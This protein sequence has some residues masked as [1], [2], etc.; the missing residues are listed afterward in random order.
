MS[1]P[2]PPRQ[3]AGA[4]PAAASWGLRSMF[5]VRSGPGRWPGGLRAAG[6]MGAPVLVG[7]LAGDLTAGLTATLG[8]FTALYGSGRPYRNRAALLAVIGVS[9]AAAV[10]LGIWAASIT[11]VGVLTVA[12]IATVA[13]LLCNS[14]EVGP[15]GAYQFA[16]VCAVG[17]G[18]HAS[19]QNPFRVAL[20]VLAGAGFAWAAHMT[21]ALFGA[22]QPENTAVR[23]AG[24]AVAAYID[25]VGNGGCDAARHQAAS[26]MYQA[27]ATLVSRQPRHRAPSPTVRQLQERSRQIHMLFADAMTGPWRPTATSTCSPGVPTTRQFR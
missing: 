26:A 13:T 22:R 20:L 23:S 10:G 3:A 2:L 8:G 17:T 9:L 18:L 11:I 4:A 25:S 6:C 14:L 5:V 15:P 12:A 7:W 1:K 21:G 19:H 24:L 16:L 27:W